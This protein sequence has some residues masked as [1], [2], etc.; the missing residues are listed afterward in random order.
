VILSQAPR[1]TRRAI[2]DAVVFNDDIDL[3]Q[4][5]AAVAVVWSLWR[6]RAEGAVEQ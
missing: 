3:D 4:L 6:A 5:E 1:A 2:A